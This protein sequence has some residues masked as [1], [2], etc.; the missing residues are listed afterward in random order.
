M[1]IF[2]TILGLVNLIGC[3]FTYFKKSKT[4]DLSNEVRDLRQKVDELKKA[5]D[6]PEVN[7]HNLRTA[8]NH[9]HDK[10]ME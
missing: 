6:D 2:L 5:Q 8:L 10:N 7:L 3:A 9:L 1:I 4:P